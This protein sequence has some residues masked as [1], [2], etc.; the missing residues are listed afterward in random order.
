M[1]LNLFKSKKEKKMKKT[2]LTFLLM[3]AVVSVASAEEYTIDVSHSTLGF[4]VKHLGV[5][6]TR[7]AFDD[8]TGVIVYDS[9][10]LSKFKADVTI[11]ATSI[12]TRNE[13]RDKHL[14][15]DDFFGVETYP[16][17]T[18]TSDRLEKR[19]GG[20]VI[21]GDLTIKDVTKQLTIPVQVN[22][23][24]VSPFG[25]TVFAIAGQTRINRQDFNVSWSKNLDAGGLVVGN[26]V[27]LI[28]ELELMKK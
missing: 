5:G 10:D 8:Y 17:I 22:G 4:A 18:F 14:R 11:Q 23:P 7:G 28:I 3:F 19:G 13:G 25:P 12:N 16:T 20:H 24:V 21:V 26:E 6:T 27:D 2:L 15:N 1:L 9:E